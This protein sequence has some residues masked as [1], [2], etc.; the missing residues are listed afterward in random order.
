MFICYIIITMK[1]T[2]LFIL[3]L[4]N[5]SLIS[6][7]DNLQ[8][9]EAMM[10]RVDPKMFM[11]FGLGWIIF[12]VGL[13]FGYLAFSYWLYLLSKKFEPSLHPA[14]SWIPVVNV[15]PLVKISNQP[16]WWI[17]ILL[18]WWL[19]PFFGPV[20]IITSIIFI[21]YK[22]SERTGR[23]FGTVILLTFF[24]VFTFPWLWLTVNNKNTIIGWILSVISFVCVISG[25]VIGWINAIQIF[26]EIDKNKFMDNSR[27]EIMKEIQNNPTMR[28]QMKE[29]QDKIDQTDTDLTKKSDKQA[30]Q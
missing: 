26:M 19:V 2:I 21:Y 12:F 25:S 16:L 8:N 28:E 13:V 23:G 30:V 9:I 27:Q 14:L 29:F 18:L 20:I 22:I 5:L 6:F 15:Y 24:S 3:F 1:K 7:A 17:F 4:K 11:N 10:R